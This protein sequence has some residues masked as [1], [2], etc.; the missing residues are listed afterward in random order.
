M[1]L[2]SSLALI[3]AAAALASAYVLRLALRGRAQHARVDRDGGS[4]LVGKGMMEMLYWSITPFAAGL[5]RMGITADVVTW[6]SLLMGIAAGVAIGMGHFGV[7]ALL[8]TLSSAGD[9]VDGFIARAMKTASDAGEVLD[10]AVDRYVELAFLAGVAVAFRASVPMLVVALAALG[11]S[12]M[13]SYATAKAEALQVEVPRGMVRRTERAV[14]LIVG[15]A[16]T[17]IAQAV[18]PSWA[19]G[20][21]AVATGLIAVLGNL[22]AIARLAALRA[23]VAR[24]GNTPQTEARADRDSA[25]PES[26]TRAAVR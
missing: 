16:F 1:D 2:G 15:A 5:A 22:S 8:A 7:G 21:M 26:A 17:P 9:A 13:V 11:A 23:R 25:P 6:V 20:P 10:A 12:F 18:H 14:I 24:K 4:A 19:L 3:V